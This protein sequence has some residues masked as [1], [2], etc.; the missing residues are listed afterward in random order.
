MKI[1]SKKTKK[2]K[3]SEDEALAPTKQK[4]PK[5]LNKSKAVKAFT[6]SAVN[7]ETSRIKQIEKSKNTAWRVAF[8]ACI[9]TI[10]LA[11]ALVFL[12]PL[13]KVEPYLVRVDNNTGQTDIVR[14]LHNA[15][16]D[17]TEE[18]AKYFTANYVRLRESYDWYTIQNTYNQTLLFSDPKE[19]NR[20]KNK[21]SKSTAPHKVYKDQKR[22]K[23]NINSVSFIGEPDTNLIQ[24][25]FTKTIEPTDGGSYSP[26]D[27]TTFPRDI[28]SQHI[29]IIGYE[30]INVPEVDDVRLI[31][32][33][34]YTV[35]TYRVDEDSAVPTPSRKS[36]TPSNISNTPSA[37]PAIAPL[38]EAY[39]PSEGE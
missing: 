32:P 28:V 38:T 16:S 14:T 29:A 23:I 10:C 30:Y 31:N 33:L 15:Q 35:K 26:Q 18:V 25:R 37:V 22:I 2:S 1:F 4:K 34:G 17:Y 24:V 39:N 27:D 19:Q 9:T 5:K 3:T 13:K 6:D 7:F 11:V 20:L 12:L 36:S 21:M 8:M